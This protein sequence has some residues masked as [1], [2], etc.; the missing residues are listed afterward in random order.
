MWFSNRIPKKT[1]L[2]WLI[3]WAARNCFSMAL[4]MNTSNNNNIKNKTAPD[5]LYLRPTKWNWIFPQGRQRKKKNIKKTIQIKHKKQQEH[6]WPPPVVVDALMSPRPLR[7]TLH[8]KLQLIASPQGARVTPAPCQL[9]LETN[10]SRQ[11]ERDRCN[12]YPQI[13]LL[14]TKARV[15]VRNHNVCSNG[16]F[17]NAKHSSV[18]NASASCSWNAIV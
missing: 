4:K 13:V 16:I 14:L 15:R 8:D 2:G 1:A 7:L 17:N 6:C 12:M 5:P 9:G 3:V 11:T 18:L 10:N